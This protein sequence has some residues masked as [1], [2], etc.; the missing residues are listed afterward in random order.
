MSLVTH[1]LLHAL[2]PTGTLRVALNHGNRVLVSRDQAGQAQGITVDIARALAEK[3]GLPLAFVEKERAIDVSSIASEGVYD[4]CFLAVDPERAKTISF[5]APYIRIEGSYLVA[6]ACLT[7]NGRT[8]VSE[9]HKVGTVEGSAYTLDLARKPGAEH[10]TL[11]PDINVALK[12]LDDGE[13]VAIAGIKNVMEAEAS[14]RPGARVVEPPFMEILQ[15]MGMPVGRPQAA[16]YLN[17][18]VTDM[19]LSGRTGEILERHGISAT[20]AVVPA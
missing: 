18:F 20:C 3:L 14:R 5:S 1:S 19:A 11:Y 9:G 10:L 6:C 12:A 2:A 4:V 8:L 13:V 7:A 15:A 17:E 16:Q